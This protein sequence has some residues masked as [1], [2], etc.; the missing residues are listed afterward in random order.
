MKIYEMKTHLSLLEWKIAQIWKT[1]TRKHSKAYVLIEHRNAAGELL[2]HNAANLI[3]LGEEAMLKSFYGN[4]TNFTPSA[5]KMA[6]ATDAS[7]VETASTYTVV[8]GTGYATVAIGRNTD[9]TIT[10][11]T[12]WKAT[13]KDCVFTATGTW[14]TAKHLILIATLNSVD[15]FIAYASLTADRTLVNGDTLTASIVI[16]LA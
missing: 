9:W 11:A 8:T 6:L 3:D 2:Y 5:F 1:L 7:Y 10:L 12:D 13:S 16:S 15:T 4:T 14:T